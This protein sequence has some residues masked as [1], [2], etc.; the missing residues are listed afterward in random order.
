MNPNFI[1][2]IWM[3]LCSTLLVLCFLPQQ[4]SG[5]HTG[6]AVTIGQVETIHSGILREDRDLLIYTP[7]DYATSEMRYPVVYLIDADD[8]FHHATGAIRLLADNNLIPPLIVVGIRNTDRVRDLLPSGDK[9]MQESSPTS[10]GGENF[11]RFTKE[12]LMPQIDRRYRTQPYRILIGHSFGGVMAVYA[13][14]Y[15]PALFQA[16]LVIDPSLWW[17]DDALVKQAAAYFETPKPGNHFMYLTVNNADS[18]SVAQCWALAHNLWENDPSESGT[19]GVGVEIHPIDGVTHGTIPFRSVYDGLEAIFQDWQIPNIGQ[20]V[21]EGGINGVD[22]FYQTLS[23]KYGFTIPASEM[24][25]SSAGSILLDLKRNEEAIAVFKRL[26]ASFPESVDAL[27]AAGDGY[28]RL[29]SLEQAK[30]YYERAVARAEQG[31]HMNRPSTRGRLQGL[32]R[33]MDA[34]KKP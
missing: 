26:V 32:L 23:M 24:S 2:R 30:G 29:G 25:V 20:I 7:P 22:R 14:L 33:K 19:P 1:R 6:E 8:H 17:N 31:P 10:G 16:S 4:T 9:E 12:E 28:Q 34:Q 3:P 15:E 21:T 18:Y 11:L 13:F 5:Q 27:N